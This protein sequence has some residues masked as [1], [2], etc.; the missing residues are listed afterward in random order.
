MNTE[1]VYSLID[2]YNFG[3]LKEKHEAEVELIEILRTNIN[4]VV[5]V[6]IFF[7]FS[8]WNSFNPTSIGFAA[9][10]EICFVEGEKEFYFPIKFIHIT[11]I[12]NFF[13]SVKFV[14]LNH[15]DLLM[16]KNKNLPIVT[17]TLKDIKTKLELL[18]L[19]DI[20]NLKLKDL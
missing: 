11:E 9:Y 7:G 4:M 19:K 10:D 12:E 15:L 2:N 20:N 17:R 6:Y 1:T 18:E 14:E 5:S 13:R 16:L 3:T 8:T